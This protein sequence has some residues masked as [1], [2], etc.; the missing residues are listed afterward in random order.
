MGLR[1]VRSGGVRG[2]RPLFL[3]KHRLAG[4]F[5]IL[6]AQKQPKGHTLISSLR[7]RDKHNQD[8]TKWE[9]SPNSEEV[10]IMSENCHD[11]RVDILPTRMNPHQDLY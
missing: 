2:H 9:P 1:S 11:S 8:M 6:A 7:Q 5:I 3:L 4:V 10:R